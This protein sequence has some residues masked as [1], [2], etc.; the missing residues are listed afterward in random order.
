MAE[1]LLVAAE[2][3]GSTGASILEL[4]KSA[5]T[6]AITLTGI[7][8]GGVMVLAAIWALVTLRGA[9]ANQD[10]AAEHEHEVRTSAVPTAQKTV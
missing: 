10:L 9:S 6:E 4:A 7:A 1:A 2:V 5:F 3:G 8:G